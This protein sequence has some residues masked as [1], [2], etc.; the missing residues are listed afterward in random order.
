MDALGLAFGCGSVTA[1]QSR[2]GFSP[3]SE[4]GEGGKEAGRE[5]SSGGL[6]ADWHLRWPDPR[7][8][9]GEFAVASG[10]FRAAWWRLG[11]DQRD[12]R[13]PMRAPESRGH[14]C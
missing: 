2:T 3:P 1:L 10:L 5:E 4:A 11:L 13:R 9:Q 14:G 7:H 12:P 6:L 8:V